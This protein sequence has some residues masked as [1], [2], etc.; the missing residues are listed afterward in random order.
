MAEKPFAKSSR[1]MTRVTQIFNY[2][3]LGSS[4]F[5]NLGYGYEVIVES[6][7]RQ[8]PRLADAKASLIW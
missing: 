8:E 3:P 6:N 4:D 2:A 5:S 1:M 7:I